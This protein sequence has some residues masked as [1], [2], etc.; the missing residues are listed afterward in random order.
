MSGS[1][2]G[3]PAPLPRHRRSCSRR[4]G[5]GSSRVAFAVSA[6]AR[7]G[8]LSVTTRPAAARGVLLFASLRPAGWTVQGAECGRRSPLPAPGRPLRPFRAA[9]QPHP[10][11][12]AGKGRR[13]ARLS[14]GAAQRRLRAGGRP[15]GPLLPLRPPP[16]GEEGV[17]PLG[18]GITWDSWVLQLP[19]LPAPHSRRLCPQSVPGGAAPGTV[20]GR[21]RV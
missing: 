13:R 12:H 9:P 5:C 2:A 6:A 16:A 8:A 14:P 21:W 10:A 18:P 7:R 17:T 15:A 1:P 11:P 3:G 20:S 4:S 19:L